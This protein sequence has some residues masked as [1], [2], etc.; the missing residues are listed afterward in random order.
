M[1]LIGQI[2][3]KHN[4]PKKR[5][6]HK[7]SVECAG[8]ILSLLTSVPIAELNDADKKALFSDIYDT[9]RAAG[10]NNKFKRSLID[11]VYRRI[12]GERY[13]KKPRMD[14]FVKA[15]VVRAKS[16]L[17]DANNRVSQFAL[18]QQY[19]SSHQQLFLILFHAA[20]ESGLCFEEGLDALLTTLTGSRQ[21]LHSVGGSYVVPLSYTRK[22]HETNAK[23]GNKKVTHRNFYP[24]PLTLLAI[25]G[26]LKSRSIACVMTTATKLLKSELAKIMSTPAIVKLSDRTFFRAIALLVSE[27][28]GS[29]LPSF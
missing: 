27:Q 17:H 1:D 9:A 25:T 2:M 23:T 28:P 14:G 3:V 8:S 12:Y 29:A 5:E 10:L 26:F 6:I 4:T 16:L 15:K 22:G 13:Y 19:L 11:V 18:Q 20:F 21:I 7:A 24:G